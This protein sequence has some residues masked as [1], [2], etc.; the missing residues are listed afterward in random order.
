MKKLSKR[1]SEV[2]GLIKDGM[3][4]KGIAVNLGLNEKTVYTYILRLYKKLGL[5]TDKNRYAL[6]ML[7][8]KKGCFK[9]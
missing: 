2:L 3:K 4:N 8:K 9:K 6:V 7:A 5:D 1:E